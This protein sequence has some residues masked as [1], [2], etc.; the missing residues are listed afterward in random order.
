M[1]AM[2]FEEYGGPE[3]Y[4]LQDIPAN[5]PMQRIVENVEKG[6]YKADPAHV[7]PFERLADAHRLM[8]SNEANGKIVV[9]L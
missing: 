2:V 7:F 8:E 9:I 4:Q 3:K 6:I 5:I 1:R